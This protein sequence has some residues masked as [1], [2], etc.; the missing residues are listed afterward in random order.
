MYFP[1]GYDYGPNGHLV[2]NEYEAAQVRKIYDWYK[3]AAE[4]LRASGANR[5]EPVRTH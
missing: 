1:I 5:T 2:V 3:E 4:R